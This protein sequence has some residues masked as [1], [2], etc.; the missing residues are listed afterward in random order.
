[1]HLPSVLTTLPLLC[2]SAHVV[3]RPTTEPLA[4]SEELP[5]VVNQLRANGMPEVVSPF[6]AAALFPL[7]L[8]SY[9]YLYYSP[10]LTDTSVRPR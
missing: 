10:N 6:P 9:T 5:E 7:P 4:W 3:A 8:L 1:M 2:L